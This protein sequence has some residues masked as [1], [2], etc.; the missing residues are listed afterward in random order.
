MVASAPV[1]GQHSLYLEE[2]DRFPKV[3]F[4]VHKIYSVSTK[5]I[6]GFEKLCIM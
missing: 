1:L 3:L 4:V 5:S 2:S 6:R